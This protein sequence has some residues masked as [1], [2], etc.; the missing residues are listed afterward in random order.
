MHGSPP[1]A[2][3]WNTA[4]ELRAILRERFGHRPAAEW[5]TLLTR[6]DIPVGQVRDMAQVFSDPQVIDQG[7]VVEVDHPTIGTIRLPGLPWQ[8]R[9]TP[10][11]VRRAPP[12]LGQDTDALLAWLGF[13]TD[14]IDAMRAD[15]V[16]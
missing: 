15:R 3:G 12:T 6:A 9:A 1:T 5:L 13:A 10:G 11:S 2:T 16:I 7:M 4:S 14:E 8:L